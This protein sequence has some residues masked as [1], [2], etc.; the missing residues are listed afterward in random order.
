MVE[1]IF[2]SV[3]FFVIFGW[4]S[5]MALSFHKRREEENQNYYLKLQKSLMDD[6]SALLKK[7]ITRTRH[8][9]H[10]LA[11]H[12]QAMEALEQKGQNAE[13]LEY[14]RQLKELYSILKSDGLCP[15][16]ILDAML[17][18]RKQQCRE[19]GITF[20][21]ELLTLD[22]TGIDQTE[23]MI[24]FYE[25]MDY[26]MKRTAAA[27]TPAFKIE[28]KQKQDHIFLTLVIP[29]EKDST[30]KK[31]KTDLLT[32]LSQTYLLTEKHEGSIHSKLEEDKEVVYL[33][34]KAGGDGQ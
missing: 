15:N 34:I 7:Q 10:D 20:E 18:R 23:L 26:G 25:L 29:A 31:R 9:R 33:T 3:D 6:Y 5:W 17:V 24:I 2:L 4:M 14:E 27:E 21:T 30:A 11:N 32:Q 1:K 8:L 12:I 16:Y 19:K 28:G 22:G 13:Y